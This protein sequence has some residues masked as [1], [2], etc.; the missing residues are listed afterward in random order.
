MPPRADGCRPGQGTFNERFWARVHKDGP[1]LAHMDS[2]CWIWTGARDQSGYG[3]LGCRTHTER[4]HR[5]AFWIRHG[6]ESRALV[7]HHCDNPPCCNPEHLFEGTKSDNA[8][9]MVSKGRNFVP[10]IERHW[11]RLH[12]QFNRG[13]ACHLSKLTE[14]DVRAIRASSERQVDLAARYGVGQPAISSIKL[15]KSWA[16]VT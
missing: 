7:C 3:T 6:R 15:R 16:H 8:L 14:D 4:A 13:S 9:D 1:T 11:S 10:P 12:P 2:P 5:V